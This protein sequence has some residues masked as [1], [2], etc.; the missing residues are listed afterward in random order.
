MAARW[1]IGIVASLALT[2]CHPAATRAAVAPCAGDLDPP[3]LPAADAPPLKISYFGVSTLAFS[4]GDDEILIDGF[5]SRPGPISTAATRIGPREDVIARRLG[6]MPG[7]RLLAIFVA[8]AHHDHGLDAGKITEIVEHPPSGRL[9]TDPWVVGTRSA[10]NLAEANGAKRACAATNKGTY[11]VGPFRVTALEVPHGPA[12]SWLERKLRGE[13]PPGRKLPA[14]F[15]DLKDTTNFSYL[16]EYGDRRILVYPSAGMAK[17]P[18]P[19]PAAAEVVFFG[20]GGL[21]ADPD[22]HPDY[23][24]R[25]WAHISQSPTTGTYVPVHWDN[26][27][28]KLESRPGFPPAFLDDVPKA[29][30]QIE[31]RPRADRICFLEPLT[32]LTLPAHGALAPIR[33]GSP[34]TPLKTRPACQGGE[35]IASS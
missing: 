28:I 7:R 19:P 21:T 33:S 35:G 15:T 25:Y 17:D 23:P 4:A 2:A 31:K 30:D 8:H 12:S 16:V 20:V 24:A 34:R 27:S 32:R 11:A 10:A 3:R 1:W 14:Y 5:F 13:T 29:L 26:F 22:G 18:P 9:P 6:Q